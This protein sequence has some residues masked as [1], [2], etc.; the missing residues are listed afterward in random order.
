MV[1]KSGDQLE[2]KQKGQVLQKVRLMEVSNLALFG[3]IQVTTQAVRDCRP[4]AIMG[5]I[6]G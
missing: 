2:V 5:Q 3:N 1:G 6:E 4:S